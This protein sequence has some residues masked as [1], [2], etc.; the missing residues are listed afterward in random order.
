MHATPQACE[1]DGTSKR[2]YDLRVGTGSD[3]NNGINTRREETGNGGW[4]ARKMWV[5]GYVTS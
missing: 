4:V 3:A 5:D 1:R 2:E